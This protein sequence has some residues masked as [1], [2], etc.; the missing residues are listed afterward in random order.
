M[1][2]PVLHIKTVGIPSI[3]MVNGAIAGESDS[4]PVVPV[5][6]NGT[7][8]VTCLPLHNEGAIAALPL[9]I[10]LEFK[11]GLP[12][13]PVRSGIAHLSPQGGVYLSLDP[14]VLPLQPEASSPYAVSRVDFIYQ[15]KQYTATAYFEGSVRVAIDDR[16]DDALDALHSPA[17]LTSCQLR[18]A[19]CFSDADV[20]LHGE[21]PKGARFIVYSPTAK[22]YK[23]VID[24]YARGDIVDGAVECVKQMN[25]TCGHEMRYR[26]ALHEGELQKSREEYG[27]FSRKKREPDDPRSLCNA[28]CEAVK[29]GQV[30]EALGYLT[31]ELADGLDMEDMADFL[32][33]FTH[34][35]APGGDTPVDELWLAYPLLENCYKIRRFHFDVRGDKIANISD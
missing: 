22:G 14:V 12:V 31:P 7:V 8:Y 34:T 4:M 11:D 19:K 18:V 35:Y 20:L 32:G 25:D 28:F 13:S 23:P 9:S 16:S 26:I 33:A 3:V 6:P 29:I 5:S 24:E 17:D 15:R 1:L 2:L 10:R 30:Q 21:G 27:F